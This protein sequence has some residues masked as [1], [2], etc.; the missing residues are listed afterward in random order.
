[1]TLFLIHK[2]KKF[3]AGRHPLKQGLKHADVDC[4]TGSCRVAGRHPLKQ[5]LK[6]ILD[7]DKTKDVLRSQGGIH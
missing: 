1:M 6:P 3:V 4:L 5:G 2:V 7:S